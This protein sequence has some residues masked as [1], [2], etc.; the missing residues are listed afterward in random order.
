MRR[1]RRTLWREPGPEAWT[2]GALVVFLVVENVTESFVLWFS[3]NWVLL[4]AAALRF[5]PGPRTPHSSA[6]ST[7]PSQW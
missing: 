3:Y 2:W 7:P 5:G 1:R 6:E 4:I